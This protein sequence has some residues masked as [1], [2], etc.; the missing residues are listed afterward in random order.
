M[1]GGAGFTASVPSN[2]SRVG[3]IAG[4]GVYIVINYPF[5]VSNYACYVKV[6]VMVLAGCGMIAVNI[7]GLF[8]RFLLRYIQPFAVAGEVLWGCVFMVAVCILVVIVLLNID[9][10]LL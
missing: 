4:Q 6:V 7:F 1:A 8:M 3:F 5:R 2:P 9:W 10:V